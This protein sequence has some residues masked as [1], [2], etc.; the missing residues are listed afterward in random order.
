MEVKDRNP[1]ESFGVRVT[2]NFFWLFV[3]EAIS[4]GLTFIGTLYLARVLGAEGFGLFSLSLS[5]AIYLWIIA[6][7]GVSLYGLREVAKDQARVQEYLQVL[8]SMRIFTALV[9]FLMLGIAILFIPMSPVTKKVIMAGS[10]YVIAYALSSDWLLRGIE[11]IKYVAFGNMLLACTFLFGIFF[12]VHQAHD[13]VIAAFFYSIAHFCASIT[14]LVILKKKFNIR[15]KLIFSWSLWKD[16]LKESWYFATTFALGYVIA[17]LIIILLGILK[18]SE[19]VG[20]FSAPHRII[21]L[22]LGF[23]GIINFSFYPVLADYYVHSPE[24]FLKIQ[25]IFQKV[26][27]TLGLPIGI[28]GFILS[29][30]IIY[31]LLGSE[32]TPSIRVFNILIWLVPLSFIRISYGCSLLAAGFQRLYMIALGISS[33]AGVAL[34]V[35]L[36][37]IWGIIGASIVFITQQ[38]IFLILVVWMFKKHIQPLPFLSNYYTK[39]LGINIVMG[40]AVY[41]IN[42]DIFGKIAL[43]VVLYCFLAFFLKLITREQLIKIYV[44]LTNRK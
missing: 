36:I 31:F 12:F 26:M 22:I 14:L 1:K 3:S 32:Y 19:S 5:V 35:P 33:A 17:P 38:C 2:T 27:I 42:I 29:K 34:C 20:L 28:G 41:C 21:M 13:V 44:S 25:S 15:F 37:Q 6:D 10:L 16:H 7:L 11:R 30:D 8:N 40:I 39:V 18:E 9:L 24:S 4:K 43:G 23:L